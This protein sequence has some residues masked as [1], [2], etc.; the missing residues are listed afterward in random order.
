MNRFEC[1]NCKRL[2]FKGGGCD[3]EIK[4]VHIY[5]DFRIEIKCPRCKKLNS[6]KLNELVIA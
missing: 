2:L 4:A 5:S 3:K 1:K 6:F